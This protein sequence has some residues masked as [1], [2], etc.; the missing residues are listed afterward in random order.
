[1][2]CNE[3]VLVGAGFRRLGNSSMFASAS[4]ARVLSPGVGPGRNDGYWFDIREANVKRIEADSK[5]WLVLR[6]VPS[7]F[8]IF[9]FAEFR[10]LLNE[11]TQ[12]HGTDGVIT[13]GFGCEFDDARQMLKVVSKRDHSRWL[14][15][16]LLDRA[17]AA[18]AILGLSQS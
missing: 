10:V 15:T 2:H 16:D 5:T 4:G 6:V 17:G 14:T 12:R 9:S 8:A 11:S 1:M 13:Y 18:K 7:G 3:D